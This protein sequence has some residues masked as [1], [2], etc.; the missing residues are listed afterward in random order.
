MNKRVILVLLPILFL[1]FKLFS[2]DL[3]EPLTVVFES[4]KSDKQPNDDE[5]STTEKN[6]AINEKKP[7]QINIIGTVNKTA[8]TTS[9]SV[10]VITKEEIQAMGCKD[11]SQAISYLTGNMINSNGSRA[12]IN[13]VSIRGSRSTQVKILLNGK[14]LN[15]PLGAGGNDPAKIPIEMIERIEIQKGAASAF[16]GNGATGGIINIVTKIPTKNSYY[17]GYNFHSLDGHDFKFQIGLPFKEKE[18]ALSFGGELLYSPTDL[19]IVGGDIII[20][21]YLASFNLNLIKETDK[22]KISFFN[23]FKE[24]YNFEQI[25][26]EMHHYG[27]IH[28]L[29]WKIKTLKR[30]ESSYS[31]SFTFR[32][33]D[34]LWNPAET[35]I[36]ERNS[37]YS[38]SL[39]NKYN[40]SHKWKE[41]SL[42]FAVLLKLRTDLVDS[43]SMNFLHRETLSPLA[44]LE[45]KFNKDKR[46]VGIFD[47]TARVDAI[48]G[49]KNFVFPSANA[50]FLFFLEKEKRVIWKVSTGNSFRAPTMNELYFISSGYTPNAQLIAEKSISFDSGFIFKPKPFIEI[51]TSYFY[52]KEYDSIVWEANSAENSEQLDFNGVEASL[53]AIFLLQNG[54]ELSFNGNYLF[55][56]ANYSDN[57]PFDLAHKHIL[58]TN[59]FFGYKKNAFINLSTNYYSGFSDIEQFVE[60]NLNARFG[61]D[62]Y[63][64]TL[65]IDNILDADLRYHRFSSKTPRAF[66]I[67]IEY[68]R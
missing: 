54:F 29:D 36:D 48:M 18:L 60:I 51:G 55:T 9:A 10:C 31:G 67:G 13:S 50:G 65:G 56:F 52:K 61:F 28:S 15:S 21:S 26:N 59:L 66:S 41:N 27:G 63:F 68:R 47:F 58:K 17:G 1:S 23:Y 45:I 7:Q 8:S 38:L 2:Q 24:N 53:K 22:Y 20:D 25:G 64:L 4:Q 16:Y 57:T 42:Q 62:E 44:S 14:E 30:E 34:L 40:L 3:E 33:L 12:S 19:N 49:D 5:S 43:S 35:D 37:S 6:P 39:E 11:S 32:P 46:E